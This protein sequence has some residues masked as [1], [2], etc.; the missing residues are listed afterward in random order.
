MVKD[1]ARVV[2]ITA[3]EGLMPSYRRYRSLAPSVVCYGFVLETYELSKTMNEDSIR[4]GTNCLSETN[5]K[6]RVDQ[7]T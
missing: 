7:Y 3:G 4:Q 1:V 2:S 6:H 5:S